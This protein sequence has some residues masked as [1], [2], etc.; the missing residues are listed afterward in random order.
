MVSPHIFPD[1]GG[2]PVDASHLEALGK[3]AA[4]LAE[5][6]EITLNDAVVETIGHEKLNAEQVRRVVEHANV[7]AFNR[8]FA[9]MQGPMRAVALD[10]GPA[11]PVHVLQS[12]EASAQSSGEMIGTTDYSM[13]PMVRKEAAVT[14]PYVPSRTREGVVGDV[15]DLHRTLKAAHDEL[16]QNAEASHYMMLEALEDLTDRTK[17]AQLQGALPEEVFLAW[18]T[19]HADLA[20]V[21]ASQV[22]LRATDVAK[23]ASLRVINP[24]QPVV[25]SFMEFAKRASSY[26]TNV[27]ARRDV[28][29]ELG[30]VDAWLQKQSS[31]RSYLSTGAEGL[32]TGVRKVIGGGGEVAAGLAKGL[33]ASEAAQQTARLVG[34]G[35]TGIVG[36]GALDQGR[37]KARNELE[38]AKQRRAIRKQQRQQAR[39]ARIYR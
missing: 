12:L 26:Y 2:K 16:T 34:K 33:G 30:R 20:K 35:T 23:V 36:V 9:S 28:E 8:K 22:G 1:L 3:T 39:R 5:S 31:Q 4:R 19:H 24:Q 21:A 25:R 10:G 37:R 7:D 13:P 15:Y 38:I 6:A 18:S 17:R 27:Q 32:A 11:D 29:A 14:H